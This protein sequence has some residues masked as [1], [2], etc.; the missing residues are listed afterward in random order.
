MVRAGDI[1]QWYS[2]C[3]EDRKP[4][5]PITVLKKKVKLGRWSSKDYITDRGKYPGEEP[6]MANC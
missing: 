5:V 2:A 1:A 6:H 3:L 4:W